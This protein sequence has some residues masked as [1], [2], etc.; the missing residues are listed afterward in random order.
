MELSVLKHG[1]VGRHKVLTAVCACSV[2][3]HVRLAFRGSEC[4]AFCT[5]WRHAAGAA[6]SGRGG[7]VHQMCMSSGAAVFST[8][9]ASARLNV[10]VICVWP[11]GDQLRST[12]KGPSVAAS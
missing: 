11:F 9:S 12:P 10:C 1:L 5:L 3:Q 6:F 8:R 2:H 7:V 4:C